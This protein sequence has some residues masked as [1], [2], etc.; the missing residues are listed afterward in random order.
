MRYIFLVVCGDHVVQFNDTVR[1]NVS[2]LKS[3]FISVS[4]KQHPIIEKVIIRFGTKH[5]L[6]IESTLIQRH[7]TVFGCWNII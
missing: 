5:W 1:D 6:N 7:S 2:M 4:D 3:I